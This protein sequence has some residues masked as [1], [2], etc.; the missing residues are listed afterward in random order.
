[1]HKKLP[2][3]HSFRLKLNHNQTFSLICTNESLKELVIGFLYNEGLISN[4]SEITSLQIDAD[5]SKAEVSCKNDMILETVRTTGLGGIG[6]QKKVALKPRKGMMTYSMDY[7]LHC[8]DVMSEKCVKYA[9]TGGMHCSAVFDQQGMIACYEDIGRHNT[10]DKLAGKCLLE[11]FDASD[12]L[13]ITTGRISQDMM[14][15]MGKIGVSVIASYSTVTQQ[16][17]EL[18]KELGITVI[19]YIG[20]SSQQIHCGAKRIK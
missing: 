9:S 7:I 3:E 18:A 4:L 8:K 16:A 17:Y 13:L 10:L 14:K 12:C 19:T 1:M 2:E 5:G 11:E 6:L 20:K 15:K